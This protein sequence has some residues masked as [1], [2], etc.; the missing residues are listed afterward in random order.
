MPLVLSTHGARVT[1]AYLTGLLPDN[2]DALER[3]GLEYGVSPS[4]PFALLAN[5]GRDAAGAVQILP[6]GDD[7]DDA[8]TR[9]GDISWLTESQLDDA[10]I[11]LIENTDWNP[12]FDAGRWSLAGARS[13]MALF[14]SDDG[15]WGI[16]TDS[17]P[18]TH[19]IKPAVT[20]MTG[21]QINEYLAMRAAKNLGLRV[22]DSELVRFGDNVV[23][24]G[25]RYDRVK[26]TVDG[27]VS[28]RRI[29]A[30]RWRSCRSRNTRTTVAQEFR[31]SRQW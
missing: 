16:P 11:S 14:R 25:K 29:S 7:P 17:T 27:D 5:I 31:K 19:I 9:S 2:K 28:I 22:A 15:K 4:N 26:L 8:R 1:Q 13:K 23:F 3:I 10:V 18:T 21:H 20:A 30:R 12:R 6:T 24:V